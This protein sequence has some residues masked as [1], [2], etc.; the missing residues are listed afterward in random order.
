MFQSQRHTIPSTERAGHR[1]WPLGMP[2]LFT[3]SAILVIYYLIAT[4][5]FGIRYFYEWK[6]VTAGVTYTLLVWSVYLS[7]PL[8]TIRPGWA[9]PLWLACREGVCGR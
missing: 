4:V 7:V 5:A 2:V 1:R 9:P 3:L 8:A 6:P